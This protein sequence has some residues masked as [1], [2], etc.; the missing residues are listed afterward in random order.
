M[1]LRFHVQAGDRVLCDPVYSDPF[2]SDS[3]SRRALPCLSAPAS[4]PL[5]G[6]F[7]RLV[8]LHH[9]PRHSWPLRR[10][11]SPPKKFCPAGS[12]TRALC[13]GTRRGMCSLLETLASQTTTTSRNLSQSVAGRR[14]R[15]SSCGPRRCRTA[16]S[17]KCSTVAWPRSSSKS[18]MRPFHSPAA[19]QK[20]RQSRSLARS[21]THT[22]VLSKQ[23]ELQISRH[24]L[25][26]KCRHTE[27][28]LEQ[29]ME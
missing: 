6:P 3:F 23:A 29:M 13:G 18:A 25:R 16:A 9:W 2:R 5:P 27:P 14:P 7:V 8:V 1:C 12:C 11:P 19:P 24:R 4:S 20:I 22:D 17:P 21:H 10:R 28:M 26:H 15:P